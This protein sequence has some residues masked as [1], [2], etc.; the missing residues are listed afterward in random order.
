ME[1]IT[2]NACEYGYAIQ[3][4]VKDSD[5]AVVNLTGYTLS[6]LVWALIG[7]SAAIWTISGT[8]VSATAGTV[9]FTVPQGDLDVAG[10]YWAHVHMTK[11]G[12]VESTERFRLTIVSSP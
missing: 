2:V 11:P 7:S 8:I 1:Q 6:L 3:C 12:V 4:T 5:D 9:N 10:D